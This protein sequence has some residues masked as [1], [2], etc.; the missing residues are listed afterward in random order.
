MQ[1]ESVKNRLQLS[2][3]SYYLKTQKLEDDKKIETLNNAIKVL[4]SHEIK[5][6][7]ITIPSMSEKHKLHFAFCFAS[8]L[9]ISG[10]K[11]HSEIAKNI[12]KLMPALNFEKEYFKIKDSMESAKVKLRMTKR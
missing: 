10:K 3:F 6:K 1:E 4:T 2:I 7:E 12:Y 5:L 9:V 11:R 8:P